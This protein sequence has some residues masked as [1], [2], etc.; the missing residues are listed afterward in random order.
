MKLLTSKIADAV[1]EGRQGA[2]TSVM[3]DEDEAEAA[4]D[5]EAAEDVEAD[6]AEDEVE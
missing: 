3:A 4:D 1:I 6:A 5:V 2:D